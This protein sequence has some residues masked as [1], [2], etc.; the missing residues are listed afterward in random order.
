MNLMANALRNRFVVSGTRQWKT[1]F[2]SVRALAL[3]VL[4]VAITFPV[5]AQQPTKIPRIGYITAASRSTIPARI[6]AFR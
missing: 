1:K 5:Q 4:V 2:H 3:S 6:E